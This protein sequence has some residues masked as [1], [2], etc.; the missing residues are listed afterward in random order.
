MNEILNRNDYLLLPIR[1]NK[2]IRLNT[3]TIIMKLISISVPMS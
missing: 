2:R 1:Y 3:F